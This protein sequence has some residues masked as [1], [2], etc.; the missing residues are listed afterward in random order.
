MPIPFMNSSRLIA[1]AALMMTVFLPLQAKG[2]L[3]LPAL[4]GDHMALQA[5]KPVAF[6]GWAD[7]GA[8]VEVSFI[9]DQDKSV[10]KADAV[11]GSDGRW[12][13]SLAPLSAG[14]T[15]TVRVT[16]D[17]NQNQTIHDVV[18]GEVWLGSGQ[19]N[20]GYIINWPTATQEI[21]DTAKK[22]AQEEGPNIRY[23]GVTSAGADEPQDDVKGSW[24]VVTPDNVGNCSAVAWNFAVILRQHIHRP[25]GLIVS[26]VGGTPAEAWIPKTA[27][28]ATSV[29]PVI[30][31][32][33][34]DALAKTTPEALQKYQQDLAE[35]KKKYPT[36]ELQHANSKTSP[37]EPY[38]SPFRRVP[39]RLYNGK[40]HGLEPYTLKGVL[41]FQADGNERHPEEYGELIQT[42]I[43]T[44]RDRWH[45]QLPFYYVEENN[46]H[47]LQTQPTEKVG[48][49][50]VRDAENAALALPG[51]DVITSVDLGLG[52]EAHFPNKKEVG[53]RLAGVALNNLYGQPG[54]V[55]SPQFAGYA[56][57][58]DKVRVR[59]QYADGLRTRN[60]GPLAGFAIKGDDGTWYWAKGKIENQEIVL[61]SELVPKPI[62]VRYAYAANPILS[63]ENQA[64]LPL[65]PFRT[66][67]D[68]MVPYPS[69]L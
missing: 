11:T 19:S 10:T 32:R 6:W 38:S 14:A 22:E 7:A 67:S 2:A 4:F 26:A 37:H 39:T 17:Q 69:E 12:S 23:F 33:N 27:L 55:H 44:W 49:A 29:G 47:D 68:P 18:V 34:S 1:I 58:G 36:A 50:Y 15:G 28:D 40:I 57:E 66:D 63:V 41:W 8:H 21:R 48:L 16:T 30:E 24:V 13:L 54:L 9:N 52:S 61:W 60:G 35:W 64:G 25:I 59:F 53:R 3:R 45:D 62:A 65:R 42:L 51:V 46:I 31:K 20:M 43:K 56:V 5:E